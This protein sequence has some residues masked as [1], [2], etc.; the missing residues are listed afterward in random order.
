MYIDPDNYGKI[1]DIYNGRTHLE[2]G[3]LKTPL[4]PDKTF[5]DD[6]L[7]MMRAIR[8]ASRFNFTIEPN[9][10]KAI[11]QNCER[12]SIV[13]Q[14]RITDEFNKIMLSEK[15]SLGLKML[16][17]SGLL[18]IILPE[19]T[20]MKGVDQKKKHHHKDV[21]YHTLEVIDNISQQTDKLELRLAALFHDIGKPRTK[22]YTPESGWSF[23]GHEV[24][25]RRM[26]SGIMKR[27][28]YSVEMTDYVKKLVNLH[29]RPMTLVSEV[30]T[31]SAIRRLIFL[32]GNDVD[33]LMVL[34]RADITSKN[35][36]RVKRYL[37][38]YDQVILKMAEVEERDRLRN[39]QPPVDG[40]EIMELFKLEPGPKVG[41][42]KKFIEEAILNGEVAND[43]DACLDYIH[44][45]VKEF[46]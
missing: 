36:E 29:L 24:V 3:L 12:L 34:C 14:E 22:R 7:R 8:F 37:A 30:V 17:E 6:P 1:I 15:P 21:F 31:D 46:E 5:S 39:F 4:D 28:R 20:T 25:G 11:A 23:H 32:A 41:K 44:K 19:I 33:D 18:A 38:N 35:P 10:F 9:T 42:I 13:S 26:A 2:Q 43:H 40:R 45:N 16:D 27:M